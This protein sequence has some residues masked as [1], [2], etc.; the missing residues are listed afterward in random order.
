MQPFLKYPSTKVP[1]VLKFGLMPIFFISSPRL[2]AVFMSPNLQYPLTR[3]LKVIKLGI[4]NP[5]DNI[6]IFL[7][8]FNPKSTSPVLQAPFIIILKVTT[9][10]YIPPFNIR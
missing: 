6:P 7:N 5:L 2:S 3:Q 1:Y 8:N 10:G 4:T 9:L